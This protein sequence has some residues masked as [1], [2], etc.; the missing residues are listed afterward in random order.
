M[1]AKKLLA[2][3]LA[4]AMLSA[5]AACGG[6]SGNT[7]PSDDANTQTSDTQTSDNGDDTEAEPVELIVFAA[8]SMTETMNQLKE[9]AG[10]LRRVHRREPQRDLS[11]QL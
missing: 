8:A 3:L 11:L 1:K 6:D 7:T 10:D 4:L 5:L 9:P 2:L